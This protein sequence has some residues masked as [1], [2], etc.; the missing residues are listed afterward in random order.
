MVKIT[1]MKSVPKNYQVVHFKEMSKAN[2]YFIFFVIT[3]QKPFETIRA[4]AG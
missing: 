2:V 3:K 1:A 4:H